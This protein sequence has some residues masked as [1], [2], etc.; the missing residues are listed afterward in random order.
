MGAFYLLTVCSYTWKDNQNDVHMCSVIAS[1]GQ[2]A[3]IC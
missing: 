2:D 3:H 1:Q